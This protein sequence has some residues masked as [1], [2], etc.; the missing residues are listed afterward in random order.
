MVG[1]WRD[2]RQLLEAA[3]GRQL[4][5]R[6]RV[7][8]RRGRHIASDGIRQHDA[9]GENHP[10]PELAERLRLLDVSF[11]HIRLSHIEDRVPAPPAV[12]R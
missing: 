11:G 9:G 1:R 8:A 3:E 5:R 4:E 2:A 10:E 7:A 6:G 12:S